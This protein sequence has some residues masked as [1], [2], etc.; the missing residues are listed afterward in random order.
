MF[1][2]N[3]LKMNCSNSRCRAG[4]SFA[5]VAIFASVC[6]LRSADGFES[7][8]PIL[9]CRTMIPGHGSAPQ[10]SAAPYRIIPSDNVTSS[11][12]RVTLTAP[13][14]ND[15]FVGFLIEARVP[16]SDENAVGSFVQVPQDSQTLDCN[17]APVS[18]AVRLQM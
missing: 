1:G 5:I 4:I 16:G 9:T 17:E 2:T 8:A 13:Q 3:R 14:V 7:G 18:S 10:T 6:L 15:Y 11:R 12:I